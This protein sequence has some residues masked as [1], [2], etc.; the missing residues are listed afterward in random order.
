MS[1]LLNFCLKDSI[2]WLIKNLSG[3]TL[4]Y[5]YFLLWLMFIHYLFYVIIRLRILEGRCS[6]ALLRV[7]SEVEEELGPLPVWVLP[8]IYPLG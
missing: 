5:D 2:N 3:G 6:T 4:N 8:G 7:F 1:K